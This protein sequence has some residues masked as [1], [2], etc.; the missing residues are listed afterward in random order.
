MGEAAEEEE[1]GDND[2]GEG[3]EDDDDDDDDDDEEE[4]EDLVDPLVAVR[5]TCH[6]ASE[7]AGYR[8]ELDTCTD[9]V[10]SKSQTEETCQQELFDFLHCA[11][12]CVA[13]SLFKFLK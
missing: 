8:S 11:D 2:D 1:S 3:E 12:H 4:E 13:H 9:R 5:E 10:N 7:C 6:G